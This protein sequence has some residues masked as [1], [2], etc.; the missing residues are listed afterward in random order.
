MIGFSERL[1]GRP[2]P[3]PEFRR[4]DD[5]GRRAPPEHP[6]FDLGQRSEAQAQLQPASLEGAHLLGF[7][8][9][10]LA[11]TVG[12]FCLETD[13]D[14]EIPVSTENA[15]RAGEEFLRQETCSRGR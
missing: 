13:D 10:A 9:F 2:H 12:D 14:L 5:L 15:Q 11:Q 8:P 4:G 1:H 6:A 7:V 3:R